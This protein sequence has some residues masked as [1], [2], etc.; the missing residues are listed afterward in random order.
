M[1]DDKPVDVEVGASHSERKIA[2][3][4]DL[5]EKY[6]FRDM[7]DIL[8]SLGNKLEATNKALTKNVN[9]LLKPNSSSNNNNYDIDNQILF[10]HNQLS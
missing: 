5:F 7:A 4:N 8:L 1:K 9:T 6:D 10:T 3:L 2:E